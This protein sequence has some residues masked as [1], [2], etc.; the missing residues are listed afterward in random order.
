M[1]AVSVAVV[2]AVAISAAAGSAAVAAS[3]AATS[4]AATSA[5]TTSPDAALAAAILAGAGVTQFAGPTS[6]T[7][8]SGVMAAGS[9]STAWTADTMPRRA[10]WQLLARGTCL[11][12]TYTQEGLVVFA[13]VCTK[14]AASAPVDGTDAPPVKSSEVTPAP[15]PPNATPDVSQA[16]T[17]NNYAGKTFQ[18]FLAANAQAQK[19]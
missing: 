3:V 15:T 7:A 12:K 6:I 18:D 9:S 10:R 8:G 17:S 2:S 16:P 14:E 19:N 1:P 5:A 4:V 11:T 13:D